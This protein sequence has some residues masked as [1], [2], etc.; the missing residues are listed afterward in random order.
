MTS[1]T[2]PDMSQLSISTSGHSVGA[3]DYDAFND[4][5]KYHYSTSPPVHSANANASPP[6]QYAQASLGPQNAK[7]QARSGLPTQWLDHSQ[8][9]IPEVRALSPPQQSD[10]S[11]SSSGGSPPSIHIQQ[12]HLYGTPNVQQ[13]GSQLQSAVDDDIIPTAIVIKNIPFTVKSDTLLGIIAS[14]NIPTPYAFNY[15]IDAQGQF[16]GLAFANFRQ[17]ADAD[18]VVAALNGFDVQ[19]RKLRV[20]YKKVLQAGE[21]ERIEREKAIR[22]M[23]SMQLEKER[24]TFN[25]ASIGAPTVPPSQNWDEFGAVH[26]VGS[27]ALAGSQ[28]NGNL[29]PI[30]DGAY[31]PP[32]LLQGISPS[33]SR[34]YSGLGLQQSSIGIPSLPLLPGQQPSSFP[35]SPPAKQGAVNELDLNDPSTLDIY[36]RILVFKEDRMRDE[37][38]FSRTL[39][40]KQRRIVHLVAQR[41]G[42]YHYSVGEGDERYAVVTRI[43]RENAPRRTLHRAPSAYLTPSP[44]TLQ[45]PSRNSTLSPTRNGGAPSLRA[46]QSMPDLSS[47]RLSSQASNPNM[48]EQFN[49]NNMREGFNTI[50]TST[51]PRRTRVVDN[52]GSLFGGVNGS[53]SNAGGNAIPPVP[54]LP[55][56]IAS[57][58]NNGISSSV[59]SGVLRQPRGPGAGVSGFGARRPTAESRTGGI[60]G[61]LDT[62]THEALE[63]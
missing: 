28:G 19:G 45:G 59:E 37:L 3:R 44:S 29:S 11:V 51:S 9:Q 58:S 31:S 17:P 26:P 39:S 48:R 32:S 7:K 40:P 47:L 14:L 27:S 61:G 18:A 21:K 43:D 10:V 5:P 20:E 50:N 49:S 54:A 6:Y 53:G 46:K 33:P 55:S 23:R 25:R 13:P 30:G 42:V 35:S 41:L 36:S 63:I 60:T 24:D 62:R 16:R 8:P 34:S 2:P 22:R 4:Q 57:L 56:S 52:F 12:P 15:H 1:P 38:A